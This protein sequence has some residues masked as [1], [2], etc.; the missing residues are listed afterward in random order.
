MKTFSE[1][2]QESKVQMSGWWFNGVILTI[3]FGLCSAFLSG[4]PSL[5]FSPDSFVGS[6]LSLAVA[7]FVAMPLSMGWIASFVRFNRGESL[8]ISNLFSTFQAPY[9]KKSIGVYLLGSIYILLWT[10]LLVIPGVIKSLS[11]SLAPYIMYDNPELTAEEAICQSMKM[12]EGRKMKL[13]L[14]V[15]AYVG[16]SLL[17]ILLLCIPMLWVVPYFQTIYVKFY[18]DACA[19]YE[20]KME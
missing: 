13:F 3:V 7:V 1:L 6:I 12:M 18:E 16:V 15:L 5:L 11:Y 10:L 14:I 17:S 9:Y 4:A 19:D 20:S 8:E 2:R